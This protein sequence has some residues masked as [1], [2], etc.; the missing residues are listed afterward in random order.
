MTVAT[1]EKTTVLSYNREFPKLPL[2]A[3]K[4]KL[5]MRWHRDENSQLICQWVAE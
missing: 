3:P 1:L 4:K 2:V 5:V